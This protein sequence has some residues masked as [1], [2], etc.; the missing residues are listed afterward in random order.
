MQGKD[1]LWQLFTADVCLLRM[2]LDSFYKELNQ[3]IFLPFAFILHFTALSEIET[4]A[5]LFVCYSPQVIFS[6]ST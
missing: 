5:H 6:C 3:N 1:C 2:Y 4:E